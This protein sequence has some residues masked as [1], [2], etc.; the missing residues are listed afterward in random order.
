MNKKRKF[1]IKEYIPTVIVT[2]VVVFLLC[3]FVELNLLFETEQKVNNKELNIPNLLDFCKIEQLEKRFKKEPKNYMVAIR[4]ARHY[5]KLKEFSKA[6]DYYSKSV[7]LSNNSDYTTYSYAMFLARRGIL[8]HAVEL[9]EKLSILNKKNIRYKADIYVEVAKSMNKSSEFAG[10]VKAYQIA[11]KYAKN[12]NDKEFVKQINIGY[13][14]AFI[15]L[16]D[17]HIKKNDVKSAILDLENSLNIFE[18]PLAKYKLGLIYQ[19]IDKVKAERYFSEVLAENVFIVNPYI[20]NKLLNDLIEQSKSDLTVHS[21]DY[22]RLKSA[23]FKRIM[24]ENYVFKEEVL[25]SDFH[26]VEL[27]KPFSKKKQYYMYF[28]ISNNSS[29]KISKLF[30]KI[31]LFINNKQYLITDN[32]LSPISQIGAYDS[33]KQVK[34]PMPKDFS[35]IDIKNQN[36]VIVKYYARKRMSAP[37]TLLKIDSL[38]F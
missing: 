24:Q 32:I 22:Y 35:S 7:K 16:A 12:L 4:I 30:V 29:S 31:E 20:Y 5:E 36:D 9:S 10:E 25:I 18:L 15:S 14:N 27:K 11:S 13:A 26:I 6:N 8:S 34:I 3:L 38:H 33:L 23:K 1:S 19:K 28:D 17:Y 37:W 21:S 2:I